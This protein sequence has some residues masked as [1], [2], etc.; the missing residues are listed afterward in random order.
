MKHLLF[1]L[2]FGCCAAVCYGQRGASYVI[3]G[4]LGCLPELADED[5]VSL[6]CERKL[7]AQAPMHEKKFRIEDTLKDGW[8]LFG[9]LEFERSGVALPV[10]LEPGL[11]R[12]ACIL[13]PDSLEGIAVTG[14]PTN[15]ETTYATIEYAALNQAMIDVS[16][17]STRTEKQKME[18]V[19]SLY[20]L[21]QKYSEDLIQKG[22]AGPAAPYFI[23][24][25][26]YYGNDYQ[27]LRQAIARV[28]ENLPGHPFI[29][30][31]D[32]ILLMKPGVS[33]GELIGQF[34][35]PD[36]AGQKVSVDFS[37]NRLTIIDLWSSVSG[38]NVA[39]FPKLRKLARTCRR[40]GIVWVGISA[41]RDPDLWKQTLRRK[42]PV[43]TQLLDQD[44]C[45]TQ[46]WNITVYPTRL[47]VG[48][49][50]EILFKG[51]SVR[52]LERFLDRL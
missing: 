50:G 10:F 8:V 33:E 29:E 26:Y 14:T 6:Y 3:E 46:S 48:P 23:V 27:G 42:K 1:T 34:A 35:L 31:L 41:D 4:D 18:A 5:S 16:H 32:M 7:I 43:G 51:N 11:I 25:K 44:Q 36:V 52:E 19:D 17:D 24:Q 49:Q 38:P 9:R 28:R 40:Q 2:L 22:M 39:D 21:Q 30:S 13:L 20:T 47:V 12:V 37:R 15:D 45:L